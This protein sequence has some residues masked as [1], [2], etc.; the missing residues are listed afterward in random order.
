M[1]DVRCQMSGFLLY[2]H[3]ISNVI[4]SKQKVISPFIEE[5]R[6]HRTVQEEGPGYGII[7]LRLTKSLHLGHKR[8]KSLS[9]MVQ[10]N[11]TRANGEQ[12]QINRD[13]LPERC[14]EVNS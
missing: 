14:E 10:A 5:D 2:F 4:G 3:C 1:S 12:L 6:Q 7:L 8:Q 9:I 11:K 13:C